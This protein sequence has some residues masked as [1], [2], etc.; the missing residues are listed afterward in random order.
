MP[1]NK[2]DQLFVRH[3]LIILEDKVL[4]ASLY[5]LRTQR[6]IANLQL[7]SVVMYTDVHWCKIK[8]YRQQTKVMA[9]AIA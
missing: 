8:G 1:A 5:F 6:A 4:D 9:K 3:L 2:T 7:K